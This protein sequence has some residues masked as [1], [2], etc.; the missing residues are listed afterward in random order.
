MLLN[1]QELTVSYRQLQELAKSCNR[2]DTMVNES[3]QNVARVLW[4]RS[5]TGRLAATCDVRGRTL[6]ATPFGYG[7]EPLRAVV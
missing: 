5:C 7:F 1:V 6:P 3:A 4:P 2:P